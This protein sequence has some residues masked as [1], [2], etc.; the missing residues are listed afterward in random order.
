M[1]MWP[2]DNHVH[3]PP[4][5]GTPGRNEPHPTLPRLHSGSEHERRAEREAR[6][7]LQRAHVLA[8]PATR[9]LGVHADRIRAEEQA[10]RLDAD[11]A[12][13]ELCAQATGETEAL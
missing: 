6:A 8:E 2:A 13:V 1:A 7:H 9:R 10:A 5:Q 12:R 11:A 3:R 4:G